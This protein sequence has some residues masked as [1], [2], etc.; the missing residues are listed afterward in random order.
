MLAK[1]PYLWQQISV[2][3]YI[4]QFIESDCQEVARKVG[5]IIGLMHDADICHGDLTSSNI[6]ITKETTTSSTSSE[7]AEA[8]YKAS[9]IDF[10]LGMMKSTIDDKAVDLYVL[11]RAFIST[12]PESEPLVCLCPS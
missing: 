5:T 4:E 12:H 10:G 9:L 11:E 2:Y 8:S 7:A 6:M 1:I 3:E